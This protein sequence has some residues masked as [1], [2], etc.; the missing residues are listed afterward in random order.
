MVDRLN[1][2][3]KV[4][5][6]IFGGIFERVLLKKLFVFIHFFFQNNQFENF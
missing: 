6:E 5:T 4:I 3:K 2:I 1:K